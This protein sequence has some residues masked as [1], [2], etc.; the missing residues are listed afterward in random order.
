MR[1][2]RPTER[3]SARASDVAVDRA[4]AQLATHQHGVVGRE[5]LL[6]L[7]VSEH[8][9]D[10]RVRTG[11]FI[12][13]FRGIYAVGHAALSDS[14]RMHAA[15]IAAGPGATLSHRTAAAVHKLVPSLPP[16]VEVTVAASP[17]RS[18]RGLV[19]HA[20]KRP[21]SPIVID[22]LPVTAPLR[23][24][25]DAAPGLPP[26][27]LE[28]ACAEALVRN[29][30]TSGD[31]EA[32][33]LVEPGRAAPTRS[34]LERRFLAVVRE[35]RL[36]RPLV[37]HTIG[38]YE[39]DFAWPHQRVLVETDGWAAHGHRL[40]FETDRT[41]DADLAAQG[42]VVLR[43]TWRQILDT[44]VLAVTRVAQ[45]LAIRDGNVGRARR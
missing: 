24:L 7:G 11:R 20:T 41:R 18:R 39:V 32:A 3:P 45:A 34:R 9:I 35:A 21:L 22:D 33:R 6:A 5:Q 25:I 38:P 10:H 42:Y 43:F 16:F 37:N 2:R 4:A 15:L 27:E 17:R 29:L 31:L 26:R 8:A 13:V 40:A 28:R 36:P 14:G 19:I 12:S 30:V 44:P 23:T 1:G